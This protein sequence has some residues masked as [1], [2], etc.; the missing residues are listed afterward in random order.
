M[1][2]LTINTAINTSLKD[3]TTSYYNANDCFIAICLLLIVFLISINVILPWLI[4]FIVPK[5]LFNENMW[6]FKERKF[7]GRFYRKIKINKWK[8]KLPDAEKLIHFQRSC[9][10]YNIDKSYINRFITECCIAELGH[11]SVGI[12]GF[13]S[14]FLALAF[15]Y[16]IRFIAILIFLFFSILDLFTQALFIIIQ[17]YNRPRLIKLRKLYNSK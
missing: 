15:P 17:R 4:R 2:P 14:V 16:E 12:A 8:N 13:S 7:E 3:N 5:R 1:K 6:L 9:L 11:L 10:P